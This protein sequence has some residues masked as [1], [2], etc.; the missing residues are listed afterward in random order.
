MIK[1]VFFD[2]YRTLVHY[3]PP[4]E[5]QQAQACREFG[6]VTEPES[7]RRAFLTAAEFLVKENSHLPI[8]QRSQEEQDRFWVNYELTLLQAAGVEATLELAA[9][10]LKRVQGFES[11]LVFYEDAPP[12]LSRLRQ[13]G[14]RLGLISNLDCTLEEFCQEL[15]VKRFFD[16]TLISYEVGIEKP[17]PEIFHLALRLA[18][19]KPA[20]AIHVGDQYL[21]DVVGAKSAGIKP[22]L[23]DREGLLEDHHDCERI[24]SLSGIMYQL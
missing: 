11:R 1:A 22:L 10:I 18:Q 2:L 12:T 20:E 16:F 9:R 8:S 21:A 6:L 17:H 15:E 4:P 13:Q 14:L 24:R 3:D 23:L 5:V 7:F 19:V